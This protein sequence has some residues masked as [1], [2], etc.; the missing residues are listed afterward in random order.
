[1]TKS[2]IHNDWKANQ[3]DKDW[4]S[5]PNHVARNSRLLLFFEQSFLWRSTSVSSAFFLIFLVFILEY[6]GVNRPR[7]FGD[8]WDQRWRNIYPGRLV[9]SMFFLIFKRSASCPRTFFPKYKKTAHKIT[10]WH[11]ARSSY[12]SESTGTSTG[13]IFGILHPDWREII[14]FKFIALLFLI[15]AFCKFFVRDIGNVR[16]MTWDWHLTLSRPFCWRV[17]FY[18]CYCFVSSYV[19][20]RQCKIP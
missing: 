17:K 14:S 11:T 7:V 19:L 6:G 10:S 2:I 20:S 15:K 13:T 4:N 16:R 8:G 18:A 5:L 12:D 1:L 9:Q 3:S